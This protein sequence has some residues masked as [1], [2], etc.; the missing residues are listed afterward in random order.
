[1]IRKMKLCKLH[2]ITAIGIFL[3]AGCSNDTKGPQSST[4]SKTSQASS[5]ANSEATPIDCRVVRALH[6]KLV[7][8][9]NEKEKFSA[10]W[11]LDILTYS[12]LIL[13][14]PD[15]FSESDLAQSKEVVAAWISNRKK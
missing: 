15:C 5:S 8:E 13:S 1:M 3:L 10:F 4:Q 6:D 2:V 9:G 11:E 14:N 7:L 12:N